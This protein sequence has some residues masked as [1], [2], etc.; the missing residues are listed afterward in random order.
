M[1]L[2]SASLVAGLLL[3]VST[4]AATPD[5]QEILNKPPVQPS[6]LNT[7]LD[8]FGIEGFERRAMSAL[9]ESYNR[10]QSKRKECENVD[11]VLNKSQLSPLKINM[12][13]YPLVLHY[14]DGLNKN[15][16]ESAEFSEFSK[17]LVVNHAAKGQH[18]DF[19]FL[20]AINA[21]SSSRYAHFIEAEARFNALP[22][23]VKEATLRAGFLQIN[24]NYL[25]SIEQIYGFER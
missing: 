5:Y 22:E 23:T 7:L 6:A 21:A 20:E 11:N 3:N 9:I 12:K 13:H 10:L 2:S 8:N 24:F 19:T 15:Q 16:C 14:F 4:V 17:L 18:S 25:K 1:N